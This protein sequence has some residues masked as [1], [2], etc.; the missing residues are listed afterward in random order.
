M[1][2]LVEQTRAPTIW[3]TNDIDRLGPAVVRRM[4]LVVRFPRP[5]VAVRQRLIERVAS[6]ASF[7]LDAESH[8]P[9]GASAGGAGAD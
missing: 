7:D 4:N 9:A 3:I 5:G 8:R 1:N 2:R 6:R